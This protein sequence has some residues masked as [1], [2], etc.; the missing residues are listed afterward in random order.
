M[1]PLNGTIYHPNVD[2]DRGI[3]KEVSSIVT[4]STPAFGTSPAYGLENPTA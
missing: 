2:P 4:G 1:K 3:R